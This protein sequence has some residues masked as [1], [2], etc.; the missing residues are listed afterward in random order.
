ME[1][2]AVYPIPSLPLGDKE[3]MAVYGGAGTRLGVP[4]TGMTA[5]SWEEA[6]LVLSQHR[7]ALAGYGVYNV[8]RFWAA[9]HLSG[10]LTLNN[11][12][13]NIIDENYSLF[14]GTTL[15]TR[16]ARVLL[17]GGLGMTA[18]GRTQELTSGSVYSSLGASDSLG[19]RTVHDSATDY[20]LSLGIAAMAGGKRPVKPFASLCYRQSLNLEGIYDE[21]SELRNVVDLSRTD[22]DGGVKVEALK[23]MPILVGTGLTFYRDKHIHG[24]DWRLFAGLQYTIRGSR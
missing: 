10:Q 9:L 24:T 19:T 22:L 2:P 7:T 1:L 6:P 5:N 8:G 15:P 21:G 14:V 4:L 18:Y 16:G 12:T 20:P 17:F 11:S 13:T 23:N 3:S